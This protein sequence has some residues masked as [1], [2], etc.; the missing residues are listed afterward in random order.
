MIT[1]AKRC[2][3]FGEIKILRSRSNGSYSYCHG[4]AYQSE[5]DGNGV[6]LAPYIHAIYGLLSQT[7][8][9]EV[10]MIGCGGG[11]LGT[12]LAKT[13]WVVTIVDI[14]PE[15]I[16]LAQQYFSLPEEVICYGMDGFTFLE[17][18]P[19]RFDAIV[20]D[21]FMGEMTP[22]HLCSVEFFQL[23]RQRLSAGG[24]I[25][26]NALAEHDLDFRADQIADRLTDA[27]FQVRILDT[28]GRIS[29]NAI[30]MGGNVTELRSPSIHIVPE[31]E[32]EEVV[33]EL[34]RMQFRRIRRRFN[35]T[36]DVETS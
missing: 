17:H 12:M 27:S 14:D 30:V 6:S 36:A 10:L 13:G 16:S 26:F 31:V 23:V 8:G 18:S 34:K 1:V 15:S 5:A 25:F 29:R 28:M 21:A 35:A 22:D 4:N 2:T 9:R 33:T 32:A 3:E 24:C 11:T 7:P 19:Q 20:V